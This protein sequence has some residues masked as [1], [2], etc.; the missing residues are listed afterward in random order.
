MLGLVAPQANLLCFI[1][2]LIAHL[3]LKSTQRG[4]RGGGGGGGAGGGGGGGGGGGAPGGGGGGGGGG[5]ATRQPVRP[6]P[7]RRWSTMREWKVVDE[8]TATYGG[9]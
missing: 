5:G 4:G 7:P 6:A 3:L 1:I 2:G 8:R 9:L